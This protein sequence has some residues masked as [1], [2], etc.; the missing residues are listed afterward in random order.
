MIGRFLYH[1]AAMEWELNMTIQ[2][3]LGLKDL[4]AAIVTRNIQLRDKIHII[5]ASLD[6]LPLSEDEKKD[7]RATLNGIKS[8]TNLRNMAAHE[9]FCPSD[10]GK[11]VKFFR[12]QAKGKFRIPE[13]TW[14]SAMLDAECAQLD[15]LADNIKRIGEKARSAVNLRLIAQALNAPTPSLGQPGLWS[16]GAHLPLGSLGHLPEETSPQ[17]A[18]ETPQDPED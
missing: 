10:D 17:E 18:H 3:L 4:Q 5:G 1:W 16:L 6:V 11:G 15:E 7:M 9:L 8:K 13:T 12:I 2:D 14:D